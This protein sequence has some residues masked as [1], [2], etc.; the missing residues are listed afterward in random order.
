MLP[1][2]YRALSCVYTCVIWD[3]HSI[4]GKKQSNTVRHSA[5][6]RNDLRSCSLPAEPGTYI[7]AIWPIVHLTARPSL[8]TFHQRSRVSVLGWLGARS[9]AFPNPETSECPGG[10]AAVAKTETAV[11]ILG[12][13]TDWAGLRCWAA[14]LAGW[15]ARQRADGAQL[16]IGC[17][18]YIR[19]GYIRLLLTRVNVLKFARIIS[20]A[21]RAC[22]LPY[23]GVISLPTSRS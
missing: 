4:R 20:L 16:H 10:H 23:V 5:P 18:A 17:R 21:R 13:T 2:V 1:T 8:L 9:S 6:Q 12:S 14:G 22:L 3:Y 7:T 19:T 11:S 15:L